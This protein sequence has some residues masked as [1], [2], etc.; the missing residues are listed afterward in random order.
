MSY[1]LSKLSTKPK[2]WKELLV[3]GVKTASYVSFLSQKS[4]SKKD[5][6]ERLRNVLKKHEQLLASNAAAAPEAQIP[7]ALI[8]RCE[9]LLNCNPAASKEVLL[10]CLVQIAQN[11]HTSFYSSAF[12]GGVMTVEEITHV[13]DSRALNSAIEKL[14]P[15]SVEG[16]AVLHVKQIL[17]MCL[18]L[19]GRDCDKY[20]ETVI[21]ALIRYLDI[22]LCSKQAIITEEMNLLVGEIRRSQTDLH[23]SER[24]LSK[25]LSA[26]SHYTGNP[27]KREKCDSTVAALTEAIESAED[28]Q[29]SLLERAV[30]LSEKVCAL[31]SSNELSAP[32]KHCMDVYELWMDIIT[33]FIYPFR[34]CVKKDNSFSKQELIEKMK[35]HK[36]KM[37]KLAHMLLRNDL[38]LHYD[39]HPNSWYLH[40]LAFHLDDLQ[41]QC[42]TRFDRP[43]AA[44]AC[45]ICEL[46]N[47]RKKKVLVSMF[48]FSH[49]PVGNARSP[50]PEWKNKYGFLISRSRIAQLYYTWY[51]GRL[52]DPYKCG[53]CKSYGHNALSRMCSGIPSVQVPPPTEEEV[54]DIDIAIERMLNVPL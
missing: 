24:T 35:D 45:Q 50:G 38:G 15:G 4:R 32:A 17:K 39:T 7:D 12:L 52:R 42:L 9:H 11:R 53:T 22:G 29:H 13:N 26:F 47:K 6:E 18:K 36:P 27:S 10:E 8:E 48:S 41:L 49:R 54:A 40:L 1:E 43:L 5:L 19:N 20:L 33:P 28:E 3:E 16:G 2:T 23:A 30:Q 51:V 21:P 44:F 37:L 34:N 14:S 46:G 31:Y 25:A